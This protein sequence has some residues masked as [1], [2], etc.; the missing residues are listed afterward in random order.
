M[1]IAILCPRGAVTGGPE[2]LHQLYAEI[3]KS[4]CHVRLLDSQA[5]YRRELSA[6]E[7]DVYNPRWVESDEEISQF[8]FLIIP[9]VFSHLSKKRFSGFEG[10]FII[11]WLSVDNSGR[12]KPFIERTKN[13]S[14]PGRR[15]VRRK[16]SLIRHLG[17]LAYV[18]IQQAFLLA[19]SL[20]GELRPIAVKKS[21]HIAQS[22]YA[23]DF[24]KRAFGVDVQIVSD[25][26]PDISCD[27]VTEKDPVVENLV[28]FNGSKGAEYCKLVEEH[29]P[30]LNFVALQGFS[31][32]EVSRL[33]S[34]SSL[35]LDL[36]H[37][38]GKDRL[39][40]E[41]AKLGTPV[42]ISNR[43]AGG[44][45]ADFDLSSEFL[46]D[47]RTE[48]PKGVGLRV[49]EMVASRERVARSQLAFSK[50]Q[51]RDRQRFASEVLDFIRSLEMRKGGA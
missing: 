42:L 30:E 29:C 22:V 41:A 46:V 33:L 45:I 14:S 31:R 27:S 40:R 13:L 17:T 38:P 34:I 49:S 50:S 3:A 5:G 4:G 24:A 25:Y 28:T 39:P 48:T 12:L 51:R 20:S 37:F 43:G 10:E 32:K 44:T 15:W 47:L 18:A 7:Y 11:W 36:G 8:D 21:L 6:Y 35:Y 16:S 1:N 9:E 23:A 2:A 26:I 19:R